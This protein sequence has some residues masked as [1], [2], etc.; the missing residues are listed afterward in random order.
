M[1]NPRATPEMYLAEQL[2]FIVET[3]PDLPAGQVSLLRAAAKAL[4]APTRSDGP[5]H[6]DGPWAEG[7]AERCG[8]MAPSILTSTGNYF[9]LASPRQ[10]DVRTDHITAALP[11]LCRFTGQC[12]PF[13]SVAQHSVMVS[14]LVPP[15]LAL[16]GLL[17]DAHEAYTGDMS[18]PAKTLLPD[19]KALSKRVR[20]VVRPHFGLPLELHPAVKAADLVALATEKRDLMI[21]DDGS[22]NW[23]I[24]EGVVPYPGIIRPRGPTSARAL[25]L[26]RLEELTR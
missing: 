7:W 4:N 11:K 17:H 23:D 25:F 20:D 9:D 15:Y 10:E 6:E 18:S 3:T 8:A 5:G 19:F 13:Y 14:H 24:I 26:R 12:E 2:I 21:E 16:Q 22:L 1:S